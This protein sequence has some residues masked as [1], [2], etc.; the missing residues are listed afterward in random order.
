MLL[1]YGTPWLEPD[2]NVDPELTS[3]TVASWRAPAAVD[4]REGT[5][6]RSP[7][8]I[9]VLIGL[10]D[11]KYFDVLHRDLTAYFPVRTRRS[12]RP[13]PG[14]KALLAPMA[15]P[16]PRKEARIVL[17]QRT[18][19]AN[20]PAPHHERHGRLRPCDHH[21]DHKATSGKSASILEP[22]DADDARISSAISSRLVVCQ[23]DGPR[24]PTPIPS[25][26]WAL[27]GSFSLPE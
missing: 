18:Q 17:S 26:T 1:W 24:T 8:T 10:K 22:N 21:R 6:F 14:S 20:R 16:L 5:S 27:H 25:Q 15:Q 7:T 19:R 12:R 13:L 2:P 4:D 11:R 3:K 23:S 9:P